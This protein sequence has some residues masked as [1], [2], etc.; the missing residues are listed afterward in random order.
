MTRKATERVKTD[1]REVK[2]LP[3]HFE[4]GDLRAL[5]VPSR[6]MECI[7]ELSSAGGDIKQI[8]IPLKQRLVVL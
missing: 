3:D 4:A 2:S 8:E 7:R 1:R 5:W 6:K